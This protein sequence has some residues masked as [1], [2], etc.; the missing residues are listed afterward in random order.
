MGKRRTFYAYLTAN[1]SNT[2][3]TLRLQIVPLYVLVSHYSFIA[4]NRERRLPMRHICLH[5]AVVSHLD[6]LYILFYSY[7]MTRDGSHRF[8]SSLSRRK[9]PSTGVFDGV[10]SYYTPSQEMM[11]LR[12]FPVDRPS[13]LPLFRSIS[14]TFPR[15]RIS[16]KQ[17]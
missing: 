10:F 16:T 4:S 7:P 12:T 8:L 13:L 6:Y 14:P 17:E 1:R 5:A 11:A 15:Q 9:R 3:N 2:S